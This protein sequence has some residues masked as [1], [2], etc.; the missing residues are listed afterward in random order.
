MKASEMFV[1]DALILLGFALVARFINPSALGISIAGAA[2]DTYS[3]QHNQHRAGHCA[4]LF[5][6]NLLALDVAL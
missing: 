4:V 6:D 5:C 1:I 3:P 2:L